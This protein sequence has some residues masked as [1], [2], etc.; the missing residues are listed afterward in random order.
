MSRPSDIPSE[1]TGGTAFGGGGASSGG[2]ATRFDDLLGEFFRSGVELPPELVDEQRAVFLRPGDVVAGRFE[3]VKPLGFGGMGAVYHVRDRDLGGEDK[4]LKVMLPSLLRSET[5][6]DRF[7]SEVGVSQKLRHESVVTVFDLAEDRERGIRFFTMEYVPGVTLHRLL[8]ERGGR[9]PLDEALGITRQICGALEY[10]HQYTVHRDLKP[11]NIMVRPDGSIKILDFGLAKLMSP[12]RLTKSSMALGTAYYQ[13][14]EQSVHLGELDA[15]ADLYSLGVILYQLLTGRI[16]LGMSKPPSQLVPG[17]PKALD[18]VV[19]RCLQPEPADRYASAAELRVALDAAVKPRRKAFAYGLAATAVALLAF[20]ALMFTRSTPAPGTGQI[21][22]KAPAAVEVAKP[23]PPEA[24]PAPAPEPEPVAEEQPPGDVQPVAEEP[25]GPADTEPADTTT[26]ADASEARKAALKAQ[27]AAKSA[28]AE[29][30]AAEKLAEADELVKQG[31]ARDTLREYGEAV[32]AYNAA[33]PVYTE[34]EN[35]A[36][37]ISAEV[38]A[39]DAAKSEAAKA[40]AEADAVEAKTYAKVRYNQAA[41]TEQAAQNT[42]DRTEATEEYAEARGL[43][44]LAADEARQQGQTIVAEAEKAALQ[45]QSAA[46]TDDVKRYAAEELAEAQAQLDAAKSA[47]SDFPRAKSAYDQAAQLFAK[48]AEAAPARRQAAYEAA[49]AA[50]KTA[51]AAA[52]SAQTED[53]KKYAAQ[54]LAQASAQIKAAKEAGT[55]YQKVKSAYEK[56]ATL[57]TSAAEVTPARK[58]AEERRVAAERQAEQE[59]REAARKVAEAGSRPGETRTF[60]GIEMVWIPPGE[61][62]MGS[63]ENEEGRDDDE[64]PRHKVT[65]S[66]GFWLGKYE[67]TKVQ[68]EKAMKSRPWS[69]KDHVLDEPDSPAVY[70]SWE[71]AQEFCKKLGSEFR[72]PSEAEWEYAC[73]AGSTSRYCFGNDDSDL[74]RYAWYDANAWDKDQKYA[75]KVGQKQ[76]NAWGLYDMHGNVWEWCQDWYHDSYTGA[77]ADGSAWETPSEQFRVLRGGSWDSSPSLCRSAYRHYDTPDRRRTVI[78]FRVSLR[79]GGAN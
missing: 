52:A 2:G 34:A 44:S 65:I 35:L 41:E 42:A 30:Y 55:D 70:V 8:N 12:G 38:A 50:A 74:G 33:A 49:Q 60:A 25:P 29:A 36:K 37:Q 59:R 77:P 53:V 54:E 31:E 3:V 56:A 72:L 4:A 63:P 73:R 20:A 14:P 1:G 62:M 46:Q 27:A 22:V 7:L 17:I 23:A 79:P 45:A 57:F 78:G 48:A 76:A 26:V 64:G 21:E 43:F 39:L 5:A 13:A 75:H 18:G 51:E 6:R 9:L 66:R 67:I 28:G 16:P 47:G 24:A 11:Q 10:A 32:A 40:K 69:G 15:R 71:D 19:T 68:W 61:F 58:E